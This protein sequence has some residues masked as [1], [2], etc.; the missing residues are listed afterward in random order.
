LLDTITY[1]ISGHSPSDA[2][3][4]RSKEEIERWQRVDSIRTFRDKLIVGGVANE[5]TLAS[6]RTC[7]EQ[8]V[9]ETFKMAV[10]LATS[11]R[12]SM[13]SELVGSVMF[14]NRRVEKHDDRE[15]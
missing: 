15:P 12:I 4:Y 13:D 6:A 2:S 9:F 3:S 1:R 7:V 14:S 11:P 8:T 10:D 5:E